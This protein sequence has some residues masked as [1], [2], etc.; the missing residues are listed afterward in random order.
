MT[1]QLYFE[2]AWMRQFEGIVSGV[3]QDDA[4]A[5]LALDQTAFYPEGGGQPG[6][7]GRLLMADGTEW[8]VTDSQRDKEGVIWHQ[9]VLGEGKTLPAQG[10][11]LSGELD[12]ARRFDHMQQHTGE[13]IIAGSL[14]E[15]TGGFTHGLHIGKEVSTIDVTLPDGSTRLD[16]KTMESIERLANTHIAADEKVICRFPD[17]E[18]LASLPLRKDPSVTDHVRVCF[19]GSH[20]L[21]ACGG[22]HLARTSQV[23][24]VKLLKTE[25]AR[26]KMRLFFLCG[27]RAM[28]HYALVYKSLGRVCEMLSAKEEEAPDRLREYMKKAEASHLSLAAL[29]RQNTLGKAD[30]LMAQALSLSG[31]RKAVIAQL[32]EDDL[33]ALEALANA[34]TRE[35]KTIALLCVPKEGLYNLL[36]ARSS[37][38]ETD[39]PELLRSTGARGGGRPEFARGAARDSLPWEAAR[40]MAP[41]L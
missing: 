21:V 30:G 22:T 2:D 26:G 39:M 5:W 34:L 1:R 40:V 10:A 25:P 14:Y 17:T 7:S 28:A 19:I 32:E 11:G 24:L 18:E 8:L 23:G 15:R 29:R 41:H 13:H 37:D 20:E 33:P 3:R 12:W 6:D 4:G 36:F 38:L 35:P 9:V 27:E 16:E 31:G